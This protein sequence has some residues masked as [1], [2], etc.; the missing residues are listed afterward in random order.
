MSSLLNIFHD[1]FS[2]ILSEVNAFYS[3]S[4]SIQNHYFIKDHSNL[5]VDDD[6]DDDDGGGE[7]PSFGDGWGFQLGGRP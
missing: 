6:D 4:H 7:W 5:V 2:V 3:H 1:N